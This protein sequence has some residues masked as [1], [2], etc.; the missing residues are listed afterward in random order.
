MT[1]VQKKHTHTH[2]TMSHYFTETLFFFSIWDTIMPITASATPIPIM[3]KPLLDH[4]GLAYINDEEGPTTVLLCN[5]KVIPAI[6]K[7]IDAIIK[8]F[9]Y[10]VSVNCIHN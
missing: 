1:A 4:S 6:T 2:D 10:F 3:T 7:I 9:P 5:V 8:H